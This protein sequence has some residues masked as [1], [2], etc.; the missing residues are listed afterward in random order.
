MHE[1]D[2]KEL[3]ATVKDLER[4]QKQAEQTYYQVEGALKLAQAQLARKLNVKAAEEAKAKS[5]PPASLPPAET[6]TSSE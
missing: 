5:F 4:Q 2:I 3:Q 1:D 6:P